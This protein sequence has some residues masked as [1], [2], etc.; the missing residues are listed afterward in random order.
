MKDRARIIPNEEFVSCERWELPLVDGP[1]MPG[2]EAELPTTPP[3]AEEVE[4]IHRQAYDEG[5]AL[6]RKEGQGKGYQEGRDEAHAEHMERARLLRQFLDRLSQP[7][8]D[9]DQEL[10]RSLVDLSILIARHLVRRELKADPG[11][12]VGVLREAIK[13]LPVAARDPRI[14]LNPEDLE[15]V[16]DALSKGDEEQAWDLKADPVIARGGCLVETE[17]SFIDATVERR[18]AAIVSR[19]LGGERENDRIP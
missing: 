3:T 13:H 4:A 6:G 17:A 10:E 7:L 14:H 2:I 1:V 16:R 5:F 12:I 9:L 11:E 18:L 19:M 15:L 8:E